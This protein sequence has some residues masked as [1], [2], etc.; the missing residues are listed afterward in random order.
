MEATNRKDWRFALVALIAM[1]L[2]TY[3]FPVILYFLCCCSF[4]VIM[5]FY[6]NDR[7]ENRED[8]EVSKRG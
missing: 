5:I 3:F 8:K 7:V 2:L 6:A 4:I 1:I